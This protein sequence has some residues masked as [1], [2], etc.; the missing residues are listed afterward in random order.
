MSAIEVGANQVAMAEII[1]QVHEHKATS[2]TDEFRPYEDSWQQCGKL[3][4]DSMIVL[5]K[6]YS[7][8]AIA[9]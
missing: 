3:R 2:I 6:I 9:Y 5:K 1:S 4:I 8:Q 7:F